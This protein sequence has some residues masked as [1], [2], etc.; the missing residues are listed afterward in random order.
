MKLKIST[1]VFSCVPTT[2]LLLG[3]CN[4]ALLYSLVI[5]IREKP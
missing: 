5:I 1:F 4:L 2:C 3:G